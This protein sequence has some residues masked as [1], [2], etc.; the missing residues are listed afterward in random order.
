MKLSVGASIF[1]CIAGR[2]YYHI[3]QY[4]QGVHWENVNNPQ[5]LIAISTSDYIVWAVGRKG[6]L[7]YRSGIT[8]DTPGGTN[9]KLI[10]N[11]KNNYP[12]HQKTAIGAKSVSLN[13][14]AAWVLLSNGTIAI[15]SDITKDHQEGKQWKYLTGNNN[16]FW[17]FGA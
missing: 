15:R 17:R 2:R 9:W 11:P 10:E 12:F 5:A 1:C 14:N 8:K 16:V 3:W 6:E 7:Y 13:K 4:F